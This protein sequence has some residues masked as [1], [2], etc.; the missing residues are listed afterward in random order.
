M[1]PAETNAD[2]HTART[3]KYPTKLNFRGTCN[4]YTAPTENITS[5]KRVRPDT[6]FVVF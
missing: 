6:T 1:R 3:C 2:R 4:D 5:N